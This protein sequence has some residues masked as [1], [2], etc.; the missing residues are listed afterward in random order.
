MPAQDSVEVL[1]QLE[2]KLNVNS[3]KLF[4]V[5]NTEDFY[6]RRVPTGQ[7]TAALAQARAAAAAER[8]HQWLDGPAGWARQLPANLTA[9]QAAQA[10]ERFLLLAALEGGP[11]A[12]AGFMTRA[13]P[14]AGTP[15]KG[16]CKYVTEWTA[17]AAAP[18][19]ASDS[20][21][22]AAMETD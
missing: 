17:G 11:T 12:Q 20:A 7:T 10:A 22:S 16:A 5:E 15:G 8:F 1:N 4:F 19:A 14:L 6:H 3:Y 18:S 21:A 13:E 9:E 2:C